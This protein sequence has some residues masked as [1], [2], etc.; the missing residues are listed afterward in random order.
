[1][2]IKIRAQPDA[3]QNSSHPY[4]F[5]FQVTVEHTLAV[6]LKAIGAFIHAFKDRGRGLAH[7]WNT[8]ALL[9]GAILQALYLQELADKT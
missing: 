7:H 2:V 8:A 9:P 3:K 5:T 6:E 1:M 4:P